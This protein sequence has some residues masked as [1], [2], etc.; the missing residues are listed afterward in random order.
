MR[1]NKIPKLLQAALDKNAHM[2]EGYHME[3]DWFGDSEWSIW[4]ELKEGYSFDGTGTVHENTVAEAISALKAVVV[5][6]ETVEDTTTEEAVEAPSIELAAMVTVEL[7][8]GKETT[9]KRIRRDIAL[10]SISDAHHDAFTNG[11]AIAVGDKWMRLVGSENY[12][13]A[14]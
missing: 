4:I 1:S 10:D 9:V 6:E 14:L 13:A 7:S 2:I 12:L 8:D 5:K 11:L 3:D